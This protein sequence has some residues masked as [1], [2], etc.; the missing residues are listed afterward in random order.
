MSSRT[1][2][3]V[4][5]PRDAACAACF[6]RSVRLHLEQ[7]L[8]QVVPA[9]VGARGRSRDASVELHATFDV[10]RSAQIQRRAPAVC[11]ARTERQMHT[12]AE[13]QPVLCTPRDLRRQHPQPIWRPEPEIGQPQHGHTADAQRRLFDQQIGGRSGGDRAEAD[14]HGR[15]RT[16]TER[17]APLAIH[18][19][20]AWSAMQLQPVASEPIAIDAHH[21]VI[22]E[23]ELVRA[24][25]EIDP[26]GREV[27]AIGMGFPGGLRSRAGGVRR[28]RGALSGFPLGRGRRSAGS[29]RPGPQ[30][31]RD[32][33]SRDREQRHPRCA[34]ACRSR[35]D[36]RGGTS[37][38]H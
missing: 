8:P 32:H 37:E 11:W 5:L 18:H 28:G 34:H 27:Q 24:G 4:Q 22:A 3:G 31:Q 23:L 26:P 33:Q 21:H 35:S 6:R 9:H 10:A 2:D 17:N 12:G 38:L 1:T 30:R 25:I 29:P 13:Q 20:S 19:D 36:G 16:G 7:A 14:R 15:V